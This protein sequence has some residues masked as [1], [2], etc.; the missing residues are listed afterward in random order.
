MDK[1]VSIERL[2]PPILAKLP[3]EVKEISKFFKT[4]NLAHRNKDSSKSYAQ[5]SQLANNTREVFKIK[6]AFL[7]QPDK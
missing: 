3:K 1:P 2:P 6:D 5:V 4:I 7:N